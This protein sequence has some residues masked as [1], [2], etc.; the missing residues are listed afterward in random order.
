MSRDRSVTTKHEQLLQHYRQVCAAR[1]N[2]AM[3]VV[4]LIEVAM[5]SA[6]TEETQQVLLDLAVK[7]LRP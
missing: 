1:N 7:V 2:E 3:R 5:Y 4:N 6:E